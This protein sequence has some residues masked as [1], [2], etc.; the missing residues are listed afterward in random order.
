MDS[1]GNCHSSS[2]DPMGKTQ[3]YDSEPK[4]GV[5]M[6]LGSPGGV[7]EKAGMSNAS[8]SQRP[9]SPSKSFMGSYLGADTQSKPEQR[10]QQLDDEMP[11]HGQQQQQERDLDYELQYVKDPEALISP[12]MKAQAVI[13]P[14]NNDAD[15][16]CEGVYTR[17]G[18][19]TIEA[20]SDGS[21][22]PPCSTASASVSVPRKGSRSF[23]ASSKNPNHA[24]PNPIPGSHVDEHMAS[25]WNHPTSQNTF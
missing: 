11:I 23:I 21:T 1:V 14:W 16:F 6:S 10:H 12:D 5:P 22:I 18:D 8:N 9:D 20:R 13:E 19:M 2:H 15:M 25:H 24:R 4:Y 17:A 3:A 7:S